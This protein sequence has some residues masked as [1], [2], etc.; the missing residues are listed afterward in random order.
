MW[1]TGQVCGK[2]VNKKVRC[3]GLDVEA[4]DESALMMQC[5]HLQKVS[6]EQ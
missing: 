6:V 4:I 2:L 5:Q 3:S 1:M